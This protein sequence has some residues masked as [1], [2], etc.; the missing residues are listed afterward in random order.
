MKDAEAHAFEGRKMGVE[1]GLDEGK[2][3][4]KNEYE[5]E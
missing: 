4:L 1:V 2:A 5:Y 3:W